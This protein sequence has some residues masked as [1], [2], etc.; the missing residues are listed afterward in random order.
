M[1]MPLATTGYSLTDVAI[2]QDV[3]LGLLW[4]FAWYIG[5]RFVREQTLAGY[6]KLLGE[7]NKGAV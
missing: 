6:A 4:S 3:C 1:A 5:G 7:R 2:S